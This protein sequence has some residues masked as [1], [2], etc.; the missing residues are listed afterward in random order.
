MRHK[1]TSVVSDQ[2]QILSCRNIIDVVDGEQEKK[3]SQDGAFTSS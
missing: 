3:R 2:D 1:Y